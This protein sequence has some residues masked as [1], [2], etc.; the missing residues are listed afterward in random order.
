MA[1]IIELNHSKS[2]VMYIDFRKAGIA[3][4][5][6]IGGKLLIVLPHSHTLDILSVMICNDL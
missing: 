2:S 3:K 1:V 4:S 5:M 6:T